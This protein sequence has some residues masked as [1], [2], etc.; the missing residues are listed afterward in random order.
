[1]SMI[2][3]D[4]SADSLTVSWP[5]TGDSSQKYILEYRVASSPSF[6][7]LSDSIASSAAVRKRNLLPDTEYWFRAKA[8]GATDETPWCV[9]DEAFRTLSEAD[10]KS[11]MACPTVSV[12]GNQAAVIAWKSELEKV[13]EAKYELQM[14]EY[15]GGSQW[16]TIAS[17]LS[18]TE[19]RKRNLSHK[20]GYQF[21]VRPVGGTFSTASAVFIPQGLSQGIKQLFSTLD[22]GTLL[23]KPDDPIP[24]EDALGGREFVLLYASAHWCG[25]CR[26]FTPMLANWY[27]SLGTHRNI[28]VVFLSNDH[29]EKSF[30]SYYG[31]MPWLAV[32]YE[33]EY[34]RDQLMG[35]LSVTGIPRL[36]V[37]D[38]KTG[39]II[40]DNAVGKSLDITRWR[41]LAA[42]R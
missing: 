3:V 17:N 25:P 21:R 32:D 12:S 31:T 35:F 2:L 14:R 28:E 10:E 13:A 26:Q 1:M 16:A 22:G 41:S 5:A 24:L 11:I 38:G 36:A 23:R 4:T 42:T 27:K 40:E 9:H 37:L 8:N 6:E 20:D 30:K 34:N 29:D 7:R 18:G 19:V 15:S 39:R 33:D